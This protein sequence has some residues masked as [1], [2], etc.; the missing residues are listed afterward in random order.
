MTAKRFVD[1]NVLLYA[2]SARPEERGKSEIAQ[3]IL[4]ADDIGTSVQVLQDFYVQATDPARGDRIP[5]EE[6][7][8][9]VQALCEF[10][11]QDLTV[12]LF[13]S[14]LSTKQRFQIAYWDA[15]VIEA[16]RALGCDSVLSEDLSHGQDYGGVRV[17]NPFGGA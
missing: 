17:V 10:P 9:F 2:V 3:S 7:V 6:A 8:R 16:A 5:H 1:T 13:R 14:A 11:V 4:E 12:E 15:A